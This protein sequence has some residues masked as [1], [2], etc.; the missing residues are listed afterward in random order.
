MFPPCDY[1]VIWKSLGTTM[2]GAG[3]QLE[4][5][6]CLHLELNWFLSYQKKATFYGFPPMLH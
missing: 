5:G 2:F 1:M 3:K 4:N 6:N